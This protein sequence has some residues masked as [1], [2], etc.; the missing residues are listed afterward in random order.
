MRESTVH[1]A[2]REPRF[3][4]SFHTG[5]CLHGHTMHSQECLSFLP[6]HLR[7]VPVLAQVVRYYQ[8]APRRIDFSRAWW[9]PPLTPA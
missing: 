2:W 6:T 8:R 1:F 7:R 3:T 4:R 9:T 5:V